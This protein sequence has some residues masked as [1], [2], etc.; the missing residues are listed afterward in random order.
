VVVRGPQ[1]EQIRITGLHPHAEPVTMSVEVDLRGIRYVE[2]RDT[3]ALVSGSR[4]R[5]A[6]FTEAWTLG[7][8]EDAEQ[9]WRI[10]AAGSRA[11]SH[12]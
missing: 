4:S 7:L 2:D 5:E 3:T 1:I 10:V 9:P 11:P 12:S 6:S 8:S